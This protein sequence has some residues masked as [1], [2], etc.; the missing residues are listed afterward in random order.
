M[1]KPQDVRAFHRRL[2]N[3]IFEVI[4]SEPNPE[5]VRKKMREEWH[6]F[7]DGLP[8]GSRRLVSTPEIEANVE[9][10][11]IAF[12]GPEMRSFIL[13]DPREDLKKLGIPVLAMAGSRDVQVGG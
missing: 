12:S 2:Q 13:S 11:F 8:E 4:Q 10:E 9:A 1:N 5:E 3:L 7:R 6:R